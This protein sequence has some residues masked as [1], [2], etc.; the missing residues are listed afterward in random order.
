MPSP[1]AEFGA[2]ARQPL[3]LAYLLKRLEVGV[4]DPERFTNDAKLV[5][6]RPCAEL[7]SE[8]VRG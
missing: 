2:K 5:P 1:L 3:H 8:D 7:G 6:I 4:Q